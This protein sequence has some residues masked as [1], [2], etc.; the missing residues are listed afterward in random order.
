MVGEWSNDERLLRSGSAVLSGY[1]IRFLWICVGRIIVLG[2][3]VLTAPAFNSDFR[4]LVRAQTDIVRLIGD[5]VALSPRRG[6]RE[7]VGLCPFHED[8]NPSFTVN[9]ERQTYRCWACGE[10]GDCFS[11][12]M[13]QDRLTFPECLEMLAQKAGLPLPE[14]YRKGSSQQQD[15]KN[16]AYEIVAWAEK[17]FHETLLTS[18]QAGLARK[19]L[20][21][22][23]LSA[24]TINAFHLGYHPYDWQWLIER[25]RGK[26]SLNELAAV[27]LIH[28]REDGSYCDHF[29]DRVLFP[30]RDNRG[31]CVA[32]GGRVIPGSGHEKGAKYL[33]TAEYPLFSKSRLVYG[34][35]QARDAIS[36]SGTTLVMEG[37]MDCIMAHQ[38][39]VRNVVAT[40]GTALTE[41]HVS[42]LKRFG[43]QVV[44]VYDGDQAGRDASDRSLGKFLS[45]EVDLRILTLPGDL[46]PADYLSDHGPDAFETLVRQ[47]AEA[48]D[49][50]LSSLIQRHGLQSIDAADQVLKEMLSTLCQ[51]PV[52]DSGELAGAWQIRESVI[53]GRLSQRL[54]IPESMIRRQLQQ[55]RSNRRPTPTRQETDPANRNFVPPQKFS[56]PAIEMDVL[57]LWLFCPAEMSQTRD[58]IGL[59]QITN[60][61]L[62]QLLGLCLNRSDAGELPSYDNL[63]GTIDDP[64]LKRVLVEIEAYSRKVRIRPE[65]ILHTLEYF[66]ARRTPVA[67]EVPAIPMAGE[68]T[69]SELGGTP[70]ALQSGTPTDVKA[71]LKQAFEQNRQ[72]A[73][74]K[75]LT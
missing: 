25:A 58:E 73:S 55:L 51:V 40:L 21:E 35:D 53:L 34:L 26:Y 62:K 75:T 30:I 27:K 23:H 8:H 44:L 70:V 71:R 18:P 4:E 11:F 63:L 33:N 61:D 72:R 3:S 16:R 7:F 57:S 38:C 37:Y 66:R 15:N 54:G 49:Y 5:F 36:K 42:L 17:L 43:R 9:P 45:Q 31:R 22:R 48:W 10:A 29:V 20:S 60:P 19:Y 69:E 32:F 1:R 39:G 47:A 65:I 59:E 41:H 13:K 52:S 68:L 64:N 14:H 28:Q 67:I 12:V 74:K 24:E 46:D 56:A 2:A 50:K 6:G